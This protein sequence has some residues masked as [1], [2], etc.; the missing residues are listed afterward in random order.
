MALARTLGLE[1]TQYLGKQ[2][3]IFRPSLHDSHDADVS[4]VLRRY[5]YQQ[6]DLVVSCI[7][8]VLMLLDPCRVATQRGLVMI[9][10]RCAS[11]AV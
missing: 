11:Q 2:I 9:T 4:P 5:T 7:A 10:S 8:R 1:Y 6:A 3:F